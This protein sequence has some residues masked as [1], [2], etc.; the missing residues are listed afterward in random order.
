MKNILKFLFL[1]VVV[2]TFACAKDTI[3]F[4]KK[5]TS[6]IFD[7]NKQEDS[8]NCTRIPAP[9]KKLINQNDILFLGERLYMDNY[10]S[11]NFSSSTRV[12]ENLR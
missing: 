6:F 10:N 7:C 9:T 4:N 11:L 2:S 1:F 12:L 3:D 5:D 8:K